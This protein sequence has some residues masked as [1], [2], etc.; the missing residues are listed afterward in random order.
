MST[1]NSSIIV[2]A[3]GNDGK[4]LKFR[5]Y[6]EDKIAEQQREVME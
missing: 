1:N 4:E 6:M 2:N 3:H 5:K